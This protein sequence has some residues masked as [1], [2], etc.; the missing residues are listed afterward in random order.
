LLKIE[1][2]HLTIPR[3]EDSQ[4][5]LELESVS[6]TARN[7]E[8]TGKKLEFNKHKKLKERPTS[9]CSN[10][11]KEKMKNNLVEKKQIT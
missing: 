5:C 10:E 11:G 8:L 7:N 9:S 4:S 3:F 1:D 2:L 6:L